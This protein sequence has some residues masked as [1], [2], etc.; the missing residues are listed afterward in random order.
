[1]VALDIFLQNNQLEKN[2]SAKVTLPLGVPDSVLKN[3]IK[4]QCKVLGEFR[5]QYKD[6][7]F[8]DFTNLTPLWHSKQGYY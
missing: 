1:M 7:G 5:L 8:D 4:R 6:T 3:E 2:D